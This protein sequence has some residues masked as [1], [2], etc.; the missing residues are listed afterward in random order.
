MWKKIHSI[1]WIKLA[2]KLAKNQ[3]IDFQKW[4]P[5]YNFKNWKYIKSIEFKNPWI[6]I[7]IGYFIILWHPKS[8]K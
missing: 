7:C 1:K 2:K 3:N 5:K 6:E 4:F 8:L